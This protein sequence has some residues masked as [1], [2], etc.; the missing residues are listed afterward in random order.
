MCHRSPHRRRAGTS[1]PLR[2]DLRPWAVCRF[3]TWASTP[4]SSRCSWTLRAAWPSPAARAAW[5][6]TRR[7]LV[8]E[9]RATRCSTATWT[10]PPGLRSSPAWDRCAREPRSWCCGGQES[11]F[12]SPS[13]RSVCTTSTHIP[14]ACL[15]PLAAQAAGG[16]WTTFMFD[17]A[18]DGNSGGPGFTTAS[19]TWTSSTGTLGQIKAQPLVFGGAVYV[20]TQNNWVYALNESSGQLIWSQNLGIPPTGYTC[21]TINGITGTPVI[22]TANNV[23]Y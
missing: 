10:Q 19:P 15:P 3:P 4:P 6:G 13:H 11:R 22:D 21:G 5:A 2:P 1:L 20:V 17:N 18:R 23:M 14:M 7:V 8:L 16:A 12:I 9:P